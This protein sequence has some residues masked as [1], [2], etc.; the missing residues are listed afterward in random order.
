M[1]FGI[2]YQKEEWKTF[3]GVAQI[4]EIFYHLKLFLWELYHELMPVR[5]NLVNSYSSLLTAKE[6][7]IFDIEEYQKLSGELKHQAPRTFGGSTFRR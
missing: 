1:D 5:I 6:P 7:C 3:V 2:T 4:E